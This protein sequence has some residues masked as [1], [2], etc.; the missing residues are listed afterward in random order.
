MYVM[1]P[2]GKTLT[3]I[4][5]G[6]DTETSYSILVTD[7]TLDGDIAVVIFRDDNDAQALTSSTRSDLDGYDFEFEFDEEIGKV[8]IL[9]C[10]TANQVSAWLDV[11]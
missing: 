8:S 1:V 6:Y 9:V 7:L 11:K 5:I 4:E 10:V 2:R 3:E